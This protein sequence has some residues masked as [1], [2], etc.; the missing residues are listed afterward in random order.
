MISPADERTMS[1]V[2]KR[3]VTVSGHKTS[4]S[5]E[6]PFWEG[7]KE[8]AQL[9][10]VPVTRLLEQID[11]GR[12]GANLSCH[13]RIRPDIFPK[14]PRSKR[15]SLDGAK[16]QFFGKQAIAELKRRRRPLNP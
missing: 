6:A 15:K 11:H 5:L 2:I 16:L 14:M 1:S 4:I 10:D 8:I 13:S 9:R 12:R 3:G 7:L